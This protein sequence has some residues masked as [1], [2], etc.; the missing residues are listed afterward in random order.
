MVIPTGARRCSFSSDICSLGDLSKRDVSG[1]TDGAESSSIFRIN[2]CYPKGLD[3]WLVLCCLT[4]LENDTPEEQ[5]RSSESHNG[6]IKRKGDVYKTKWMTKFII[7]ES[8]FYSVNLYLVIYFYTTLN[9]SVVRIYYNK[10]YVHSL[11]RR[12]IFFF[13]HEGLRIDWAS[14]HKR[15]INCIC[16]RVFHGLSDSQHF[17]SRLQP[18]SS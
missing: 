10:L 12:S 9:T 3:S 17:P 18:K 5:F 2:S 8:S 1:A 11:G 6:K 4:Y 15:G 14:I 16:W 7:N 13:I